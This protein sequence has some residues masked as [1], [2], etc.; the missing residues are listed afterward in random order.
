[1]CMKITMSLV[2]LFTKRKVERSVIVNLM[3]KQKVRLLIAM[4]MFTY[5]LEVARSMWQVLSMM[6]KK[7]ELYNGV[8]VLIKVFVLI[9]SMQL[10]VFVNARAM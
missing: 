9:R 8:I 1:M 2:V 10:K 5:M 6:L 3:L 7:T 4:F